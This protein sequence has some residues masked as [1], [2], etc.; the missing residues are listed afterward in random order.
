MQ[1][2]GWDPSTVSAGSNKKLMWKC[3]SNHTWLATPNNRKNG[4]GC[5]SC[6]GKVTIAGQNDLATTDPEIA[7]EAHGWDPSAIRRGSEKKMNWQC[8]SGHQWTA[9][10]ADRAR[11]RG[12]PYCFGRLAIPGVEDLATLNPLLAAE[13]DGWDPS[14]LSPGSNKKVG[15]KCSVGHR[16]VATVNSRNNGRGCPYCSGRLAI[17][18]E[19]DLASTHPILAM[20]AFGWDPSTLGPG[21]VKQVEWKCGEGH[22]WKTMVFHRVNGNGCPYCGNRRVLAGW[23][24]LATTNPEIAA[25]AV[26]WDPTTRMAGSDRRVGWQCSL[27]HQWEAAINDRKFGGC[28]YCSGQKILKGFND[29]ATRNSQLATESDGWDPSTLSEGSN[30]KVS[31]R[32]EFG[33]V[34]KATPN[35][36]ARGS[37]CPS[38][39][40]FGFDPNKEAWLYFL[41]HELW[42]LLQIGITNSPKSRIS[43][44]QSSGWQVIDLRGSMAGEVTKRWEQDILAALRDRGVN[45]GPEQIAGRF[46][47]YTESWIRD[48]F[49]AQTLKELMGLVFEDGES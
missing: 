21:S 18:G 7:A 5:P 19:N 4:T 3:E 46:S 31:W 28:P 1:A 47:G 32:C 22:V 38:C 44:H 6:A 9:S 23:N 14:T 42:G 13:A 37:G 26:G 49:P 35:N 39:A 48:D 41:E 33:H 12:C 16:W 45:L 15:W 2:S 8:T 34:W 30:Q 25:Q 43:K 27:G 20:E 10:V 29:L 24:D 11:G 36:R 40:T 17:A